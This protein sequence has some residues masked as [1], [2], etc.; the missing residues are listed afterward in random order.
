MKKKGGEKD[1]ARPR[2]RAEGRAGGR[3]AL[4]GVHPTTCDDPA[5]HRAVVMVDMVKDVWKHCGRKVTEKPQG[6]NH[7]ASRGCFSVRFVSGDAL[8]S[9]TVC[10]SMHRQQIIDVS[11]RKPPADEDA[12]IIFD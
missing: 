9:T 5:A 11:R 3:D 7:A 1:E 4:L 10:F 2:G 8:K 12:I 6:V